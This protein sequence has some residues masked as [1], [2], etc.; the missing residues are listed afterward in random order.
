MHTF[1]D[2]HILSETFSGKELDVKIY[3][4][5]KTIGRLPEVADCAQAQ[6]SSF[7]IPPPVCQ[8]YL[9]E[10]ILSAI[11]HIKQNIRIHFWDKEY[12]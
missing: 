8:P 3:A 7:L 9:S 12:W 2:A 5:S 10:K 11:K 4:S 1:H 6:H